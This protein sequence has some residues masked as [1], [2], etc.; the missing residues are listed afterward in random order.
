MAVS[1]YTIT[2]LSNYG[3][4]ID[5]FNGFFN[6]TNF[7]VKCKLYGKIQIMGS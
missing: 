6:F 4:G 7:M 1:Y 5:T 2:I 3:V